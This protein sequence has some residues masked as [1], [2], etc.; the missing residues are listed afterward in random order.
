MEDLLA[1]EREKTEETQQV[2]QHLERLIKQMENT[3]EELSLLQRNRGLQENEI[4]RLRKENEALRYEREK[5]TQ[6][7]RD[8]TAHA[9][10]LQ[11]T[12]D[13][14]SAGMFYS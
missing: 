11:S 13:L 7:M 14:Q 8:V 3:R 9:E 5:S 10:S 4:Q 12:V 6:K 1:T 2:K